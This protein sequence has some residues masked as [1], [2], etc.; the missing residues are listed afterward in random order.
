MINLELIESPKRGSFVIT[1]K[2][3]DVLEQN[4]NK[5]DLRFLKSL[6]N[7]NNIEQSLKFYYKMLVLFN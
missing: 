2:G 5:I 4:P 7:E 6:D 1:Q 3:L